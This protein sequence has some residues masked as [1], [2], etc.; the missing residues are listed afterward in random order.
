MDTLK[1]LILYY[2]SMVLGGLLM[3]LLAMALYAT[4]L[5]ILRNWNDSKR[6]RELKNEDKNQTKLKATLSSSFGSCG[7]QQRSTGTPTPKCK[8]PS[9]Q[10]YLRSNLKE[11]E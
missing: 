4:M 3:L 6:S 7:L 2:G 11:V 1:T 9:K 8:T 10:R 5:V